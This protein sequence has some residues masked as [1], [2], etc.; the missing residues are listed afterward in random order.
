M[1][2][3]PCYYADADAARA[4]ARRYAA[5]VR[6]SRATWLLQRARKRKRML[7]E[8]ERRRARYDD[9]NMMPLRAMRY[10]D[11]IA[12]RRAMRDARAALMLRMILLL[13]LRVTASV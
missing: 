2:F 6:L 9:V 8:R 4:A 1:I 11:V 10:D 3:A 12:R 13:M 5:I 7:R